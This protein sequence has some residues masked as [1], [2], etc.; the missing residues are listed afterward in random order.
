MKYNTD[1]KI[2]EHILENLLPTVFKKYF[3]SNSKVFYYLNKLKEH[4]QKIKFK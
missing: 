1:K 2:L 3:K 4:S